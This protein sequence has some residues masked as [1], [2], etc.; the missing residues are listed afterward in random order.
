MSPEEEAVEQLE[1]FQVAEKRIALQTLANLDKVEQYSDEISKL[2]EDEEAAV[3]REAALT[4]GKVKPSSSRSGQSIVRTLA[5]SLQDEDKSVRAEVAR[6]IAALGKDGATVA[7]RV[8][9][10]LGKEKDEEPALAAVE[11]LSSMGEAIRLGPFLGHSSA[12]VLRVALVEVG[13]SPQARVK[14][15]HLIQERLSHQD[16]SVRLAAVQASSEI[17]SSCSEAHFEALAALRT[18]DRQPKVRRAAVQALGKAGSVG[19]PYLV[20][21][22]HD[23]DDAV[24]HFAAETLGGIGGEGSAD[25]AAELAEHED[26]PVRRAALMALGKLKVDGRDRSSLVA[27]HL[28]DDDFAAKLAAIQALSDLN[29]SEEAPHVG[30]LC[31]DA[32]KGVRQAAV[33]ALAKMGEGGAA[34]AIKF[35]DDADEAVRQAAVKVYSPLHSKLPADLAMP[36]VGEVCRKLNDEDWRVRQAAVVALGDLHTGQYAKEVAIMCNDDNNQ[37]RRSAIVSLVK[38][39]AT[40]SCAAA[41]LLDEDAGVKKEAEKAYA[42]LKANGPDD[43]DLSECD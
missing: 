1:A 22:F 29:A 9:K 30:A 23:A 33:A 2:L 5:D 39:G 6:S 31:K 32:N 38:F 11:C 26:G 17:G 4:L 3:R 24:R 27:K 35:L 7:D 40:A 36:Y 28:H 21:Y 16:T 34:E 43:S 25:A 14:F 37:V 8:E 15:A 19:V 10:I 42:D 12:N 18:T 41:F 13:R 20:M